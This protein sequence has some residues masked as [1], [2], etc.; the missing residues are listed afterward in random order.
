VARVHPERPFGSAESRHGHTERPAGHVPPATESKRPSDHPDVALVGLWH[1]GSVAAAGWT[2]T[3][4]SVLAWDPE[5]ELASTIESGEGAVVEPGLDQAL[6]SALESGLLTIVGDPVQAI[7]HASVTHLAYDTRTGRSGHPDDARLDEAVEMFAKVAPDDAL[8]LVSSQLPVGTSRGWRDLLQ[9]QERGLL[10]AHAP[11]NLRLGRALEDFL[12]PD[13]LVVGAD[14]ADAFARAAAALEP[15]STAPL[16]VGLASAEMTKHATNAYL[17]LCIA[18][19]NDLAWMSL[20]AGADP[21]EVATGLLADPRVS[22]S[23]PL[24]P[25]PAFSGATLTRDLVSLRA[26]GE[27]CGRPDLVAAIIEANE[28]HAEVALAWLEEALGSLGGTHVALAGLTYKPG[29]S[30]LRDSLP[31]RLVSQLLERGAT[32][33]AWDPAADELEARAGLARAGS[34]EACVEEADAL[35]VMT[36]LPQLR[37]V[38]WSRLRPR[39]RLVVDGCMGVDRVAAEGAGWT[40]RGLAGA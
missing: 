34:L 9:A 19:A 8:L 10:L 30:T 25:G 36:A 38:D 20:S 39:R 13:R 1:L 31:L 28:R 32:V 11:E 26:L 7:A 29:T 21:A 23:A 22:D 4:R 37:E 35:A 27:R 17:A 18:F 3:G 6:R 12:H 15:F 16:R 33:T 24:R 5:P 14:D 2:M 40:Y